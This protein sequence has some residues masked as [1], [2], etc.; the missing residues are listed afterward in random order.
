MKRGVEA[1][2]FTLKRALLRDCDGS[3]LKRELERMLCDE[4]HKNARIA[5]VR[6][7]RGSHIGNGST[8]YGP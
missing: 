8:R 1:M 3:H 2:G 7:A 6:C 5:R 4:D